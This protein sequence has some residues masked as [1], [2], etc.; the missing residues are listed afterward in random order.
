MRRD[1]FNDILV[2][3]EDEVPHTPQRWVWFADVATSTPI[4]RPVEPREERTK[5]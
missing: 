1:A 3:S 4:P 5:L 2:D